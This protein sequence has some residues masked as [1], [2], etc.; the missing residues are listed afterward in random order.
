M[1]RKGRGEKGGFHI[2]FFVHKRV[3]NWFTG[4]SSMPLSFR[5]LSAGRSLRENPKER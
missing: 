1:G 5:G 3:R 2:T 4:H